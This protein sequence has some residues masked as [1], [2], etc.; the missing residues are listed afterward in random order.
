MK[1]NGPPT[2]VAGH[3]AVS[4][5]TMGTPFITIQAGA[6]FKRGV[7]Q[8][9]VPEPFPA[10]V[11]CCPAYDTSAQQGRPWYRYTAARTLRVLHASHLHAFVASLYTDQQLAHMDF[12]GFNHFSNPGQEFRVLTKLATVADDLNIDGVF[13]MQGDGPVFIFMGSRVRHSAF[14]VDEL[15]SAS[16]SGVTTAQDEPAPCTRARHS[17]RASH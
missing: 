2:Q 13:R 15:Q 9:V 8:G 5:P 11:W 4:H 17:R 12:L 3:V 1:F 14:E 16:G 7:R 10:S 6:V